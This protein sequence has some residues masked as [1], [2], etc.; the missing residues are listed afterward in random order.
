MDIDENTREQSIKMVGVC[1][2][3]LRLAQPV[4]LLQIVRLAAGSHTKYHASLKGQISKKSKES[5]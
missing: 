1:L 5:M 2:R 3:I 4:L